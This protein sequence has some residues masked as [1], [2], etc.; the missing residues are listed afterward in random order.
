MSE[1]SVSQT[2][3]LTLINAAGRLMA[4]HGIDELESRA[5]TTAR[6][7]ARAANEST[8]AIH[9]HFGT[10]EDL[11]NAVINY[12]IQPWKDDP[13]GKY[14]KE[15]SELLETHDG[16]LN[17]SDA[18]L[19]LFFEAIFPSGSEHAWHASFMFK[20]FQKKSAASENLFLICVNP[21]INAFATI[22]SKATGSNN[23]ITAKAWAFMVV[24]PLVFHVMDFGNNVYLFEEKEFPSSFSET[25]KNLIKNNVR[26][27]FQNIEA[28]VS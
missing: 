27:S 17:L 26:I 4:L 23:S 20:F 21:V 8:G 16:I 6:A 18:L 13:L 22:Y 3:R 12:A 11:L 5:A 1:Y 28:Q 7:I 19:D 2:T 10:R 24:T 9:Y 15:H 14:I 25:L